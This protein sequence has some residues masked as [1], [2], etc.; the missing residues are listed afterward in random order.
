[1]GA[2][3]DAHDGRQRWSS[4][5][6]RGCPGPLPAVMK[7]A[8]TKKGRASSPGRYVVRQAT[9]FS[10]E[11]CCPARKGWQSKLSSVPLHM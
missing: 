11:N 2:S 5:S 4:A 6:K 10:D 9:G 1:M 3:E 7:R 8:L